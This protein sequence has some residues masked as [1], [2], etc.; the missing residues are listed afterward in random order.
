MREIAA[1]AREEN[2]AVAQL[3]AKAQKD[4]RTVKVLTFVAMLYL[5]A[6]LIAVGLTPFTVYSTS[7][8]MNSLV[9]NYADD[10]RPMAKRIKSRPSSAR[11]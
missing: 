8:L 1:A 9:K 5:P 7:V 3:L 11:I 4:S 10:T 2:K 6:S